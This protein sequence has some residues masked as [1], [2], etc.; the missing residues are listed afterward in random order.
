MYEWRVQFV[1]TTTTS[2]H[3]IHTHTHIVHHHHQHHRKRRA[4]RAL[5]FLYIIIYI[6]HTLPLIKSIFY[7][8]TTTMYVWWNKI[9]IVYSLHHP[10]LENGK[11]KKQKLKKSHLGLPDFL[12]RHFKTKKVTGDNNENSEANARWSNFCSI[13]QKLLYHPKT[14]LLIA[15]EYWKKISLR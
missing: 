4:L 3:I 7:D 11:W 5:F 10:H 12:S 6:T 8:D 13:E 15:S 2:P 1:T 9:R 14:L